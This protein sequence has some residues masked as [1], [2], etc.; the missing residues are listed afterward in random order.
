MRVRLVWHM[1]VSRADKHS[2]WVYDC[3]LRADKIDVACVRFTGP[4]NGSR[5]LAAAEM[6][7]AISFMVMSQPLA[8]M[9]GKVFDYGIVDTSVLGGREPYGDTQP[10]E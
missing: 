5:R 6:M 7:D 1:S 2:G 9:S 10:E 3:Y 8:V 4:M